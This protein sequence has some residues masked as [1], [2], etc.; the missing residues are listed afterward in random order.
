MWNLVDYYINKQCTV[1]MC[2]FYIDI[3]CF[4]SQ[5]TSLVYMLH[6]INILNLY[7]SL[8]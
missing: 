2:F 3:D 7:Y 4:S 8:S 6:S 5:I 1:H